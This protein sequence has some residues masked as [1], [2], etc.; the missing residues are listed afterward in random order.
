MPNPVLVMDYANLFCGSAPENDKASNHLTLMSVELPTI[1]VQYV[2]HRPGGSP[3][4]IEVDVI[5]ARFEIRF[6]LIGM[7]RQVMELVGKYVVGAND[8]FF[9]GNCRDYLTGLTI[10]AE[11]IVR[12]QLGRVEP[13][14]FRRG[15]VF[16]TKYQIRG[17]TRYTFNL[18]NRPVYDWDFF[19]TTWSV[20]GINQNGASTAPLGVELD[21]A[22]NT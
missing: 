17:L 6:E 18:A 19:T 5:M 14:A 8:F 22:N 21:T 7:T 20:G 9:Y 4:A 3:V 16:S 15:N 12:G 13:G 10:Q 11:A 1:D 2:Y